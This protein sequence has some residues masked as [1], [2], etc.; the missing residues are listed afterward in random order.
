MK[1]RF[2]LPGAMQRGKVQFHIEHTP[3]AEH[4]LAKSSGMQKARR[5][6][7]SIRSCSLLSGLAMN[8]GQPPSKQRSAKSFY[9]T[10]HTL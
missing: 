5:L 7:I 3:A 4:H 9:T 6:R 10:I 1:L 8:F 2:I